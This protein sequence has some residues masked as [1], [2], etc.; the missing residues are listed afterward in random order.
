MKT[1]K[2]L[3]K[4]VETIW[5]VLNTKENCMG[6]NPLG[7]SLASQDCRSA[8][9]NKHLIKQGYLADEITDKTDFMTK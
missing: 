4:L 5:F 1:L 6:S 2:L 8:Q 9:I 3:G 7:V